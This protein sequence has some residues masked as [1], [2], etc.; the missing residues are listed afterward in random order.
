MHWTFQ[1]GPKSVRGE[2]QH[3]SE[4]SYG[5]VRYCDI[6]GSRYKQSGNCSSAGFSSKIINTEKSITV[7]DTFQ[8]FSVGEDSSESV[9]PC[10]SLPL[11]VQE[12]IILQFIRYII[13]LFLW[14]LIIFRMGSETCSDQTHGRLLSS[15]R[16]VLRIASA[17]GHLNPN[18]W[19][20]WNWNSFLNMEVIHSCGQ[21]I[22]IGSK[23]CY[24]Y[25]IYI[26]CK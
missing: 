21:V 15:N 12:R 19:F 25:W 10:G 9:V 22:G 7:K 8:W 2:L 11:V 24:L 23:V 17:E 4:S 14:L 16:R 18:V 26:Y 20:N 1:Y 13:E 6:G 5:L 3:L